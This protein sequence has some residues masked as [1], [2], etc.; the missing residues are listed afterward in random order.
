MNWLA[1][2]AAGGAGAVAFALARA[3]AAGLDLRGKVLI[4]RGLATGVPKSVWNTNVGGR[5]ALQECASHGYA[6]GRPAT[7]YQ[8]RWQYHRANAND[9]GTPPLLRDFH[10]AKK[11]TAT[12]AVGTGLGD[13]VIPYE[14]LILGAQ[15]AVGDVTPPPTMTASGSVWGVQTLFG[16]VGQVAGT[17]HA[18]GPQSAQTA[19]STPGKAIEGG[20][21]FETVGDHNSHLPAIVFGL[22]GAWPP[23]VEESSYH[24]Q[25]WLYAWDQWR[26][27]HGTRYVSFLAGLQLSHRN[28]ALTDFWK[29][30]KPPL[31]GS[32]HFMTRHYYGTHICRQYQAA[33][34]AI[35][36]AYTL[37]C[38][39][40]ACLGYLE[41]P[42]VIPS[43]DYYQ[44]KAKGL[45]L[46]PPGAG[47][48]TYESVLGGA[49]GKAVKTLS[50]ALKAYLA[51][52]GGFKKGS[53][54]AA[55]VGIA[56][57]MG[58]EGYRLLTGHYGPRGADKL[59]LPSWE[60]VAVPLQEVT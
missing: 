4:P 48:A 54:I 9:P 15:G 47:A 26:R 20:G 18:E 19:V 51:A 30:I 57:V 25:A 5:I 17:D 56:A 1:V 60:P 37:S 2:L 8:K 11:V 22:C 28:A 14:S 27:C 10:Q 46:Q 34:E 42:E 23:A 43:W 35:A 32:D 33:P 40:A 41:R 59:L 38:A 44:S 29:Q 21:W 6:T 24:H 16:I 31:W 45:Q 12:G 50:P 49:T 53:A 52:G 39:L 58:R 13:V 36:Y 55:G 3:R 7:G